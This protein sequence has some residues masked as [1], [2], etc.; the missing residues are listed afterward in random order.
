MKKDGRQRKIDSL[1]CETL[2]RTSEDY[3]DREDQSWPEAEVCSENWLADVERVQ[4]YVISKS[5][6]IFVH[7]CIYTV[8]KNVSHKQFI[9]VNYMCAE[10]WRGMQVSAI[11]LWCWGTQMRQIP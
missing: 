10:V 11:Y 4:M 8:F 1:F 7:K 9:L 5:F 3:S 2:E 6:K